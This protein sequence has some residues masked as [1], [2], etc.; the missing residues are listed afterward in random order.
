MHCTACAIDIDGTLEDTKGVKESSTNYAKQETKVTF[1]QEKLREEK[2][3]SII[4]TL[5]YSSEIQQ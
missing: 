1:N 5:G 4:K 2:I 3:V